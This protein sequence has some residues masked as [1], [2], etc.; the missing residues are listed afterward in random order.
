MASVERLDATSMASVGPVTAV[1]SARAASGRTAE[2]WTDIRAAA[3]AASTGG[4]EES[5]PLDGAAFAAERLGR[6]SGYTQSRGVSKTNL[7]RS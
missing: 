6:R 4:L 1:D 2:L 5:C 7:T 3:M